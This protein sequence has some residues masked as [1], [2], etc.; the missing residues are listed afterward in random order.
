[1][2]VK[3]WDYKVKLNFFIQSFLILVN[4]WPI[5]HPYKKIILYTMCFTLLWKWSQKNVL[6]LVMA[7]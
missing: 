3:K 1:M 4:I 6:K 7:V 2:A 5:W